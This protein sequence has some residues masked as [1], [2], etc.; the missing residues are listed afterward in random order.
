MLKLASRLG[1]GGIGL[2]QDGP[3]VADCAPLDIVSRIDLR[4]R[5]ANDLTATLR[6]VRRRYEIV[7]VECW[8]KNIARQA[9][10][11]N[12]V[13]VLNFPGSASERRRVRF[14][15]Q[16]ASLAEDVNCAF[17]INVSDLLG[18]G[19]LVLSK[20]L[21]II[22]EEVENSVRHRVP[23]VVSSGAHGPLAMRD[24]RSLAAVLSLVDIDEE[25][26]LDTVS[27]NPWDLVERNREKLGPDFV[28]PGVRR[29]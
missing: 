2:V 12:R 3:A 13:D 6:K 4:P 7:A 16:E 8:S 1:Y 23:V 21:T 24:P 22:R 19:P 29:I 20:L 26:S 9:A 28:M 17:E 18:A 15:R 14:D 11:D 5:N 25:R 10:K 27:T